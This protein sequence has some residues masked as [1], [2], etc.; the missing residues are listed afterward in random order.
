MQEF[1][2]EIINGLQN[3]PETAV[4]LGGSALTLGAWK[5]RDVASSA[6]DEV[7]KAVY[8]PVNYST[9]DLKDIEGPVRGYLADR[10]RRWDQENLGTV[11]YQM[12]DD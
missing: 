9:S 5:G 1:V 12:S 6:L 8:D 11:D 3:N 10:R 7:S 2:N 4:A